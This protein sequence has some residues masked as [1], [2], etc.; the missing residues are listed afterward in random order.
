MWTL[1][2][3]EVEIASNAAA[4]FTDALVSSQIHLL[5][6]DTAPQTLNEHV[7]TP[8][9]L[10]IHTDRYSPVGKRAGERRSGE[11]AALI[12]IEDF[13]LAVTSQCIFKG[14]NTERGL[15]GDRQPPRQHTATEP[16]EHDGEVDKALR[17]RNICDVHRP[18]LVGPRDLDPAK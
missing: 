2:I 13:R 8:S 10:A 15:H 12:R 17:H 4:G 6:F 5:V 7:V 1:A 3:V 14:R 9:A 11:L 16:I 18:D